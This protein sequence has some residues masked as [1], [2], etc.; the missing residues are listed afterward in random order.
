MFAKGT[1]W[2]RVWVSHEVE[3]W[4]AAGGRAASA[5]L[6]LGEEVLVL[7]RRESK[8]GVQ[9]GAGGNLD[10][11]RWD[12]ACA[13]LMS[14]E[15]TRKRPPNPKYATIRWRSLDEKLRGALLANP[16]IEKVDAD[17]RRECKSAFGASDNPRCAK[18]DAQLTQ[19]V[20]DHVRK[21]AALP[22]PDSVP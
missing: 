1:P 16:S 4:N 17:R 14:D 21:G 20:V 9:V 12:G 3:A 11:L 18:F 6:E 10:V 8:G 7:V 13:S 15:I 2:T 22:F 19:L 5:K